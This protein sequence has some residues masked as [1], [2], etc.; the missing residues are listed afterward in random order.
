MSLLVAVA[1]SSHGRTFLWCP[2]ATST[3]AKGKEARARLVPLLPALLL[4]LAA[5]ARAC[6]CPWARERRSAGGELC[7]LG[8][9]RP[10]ESVKTPGLPFWCPQ[11]WK[12]HLREES[13]PLPPCLGW[14]RKRR[15][16]LCCPGLLLAGTAGGQ[17]SSSTGR[18]ASV[19]CGCGAGSR[20]SGLEKT[21][22]HLQLGA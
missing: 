14:G 2:C 8:A 22:P 3:E 6:P 5:I 19:G 17:G 18:G 12:P 11:F 4:L 13:A 7:C 21:P 10:M 20:D 1:V 15:R 9:C 16:L